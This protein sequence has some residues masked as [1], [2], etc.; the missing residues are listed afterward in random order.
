MALTDKKAK[1][2]EAMSRR[3][4]LLRRNPLDPFAPE[5]DSRFRAFVMELEDDEIPF[6]MDYW[7]MRCH[8]KRLR[9]LE[10]SKVECVLCGL[11]MEDNP[12]LLQMMKDEWTSYCPDGVDMFE[13]DDLFTKKRSTWQYIHG[14][15]MAALV[16][17]VLA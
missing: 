8:H 3:E 9:S 10:G 7:H 13:W 2:E 1:A 15:V 4:V 5:P 16:E 14:E 17:E 11:V 12:D 6:V